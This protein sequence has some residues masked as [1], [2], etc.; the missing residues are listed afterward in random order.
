MKAIYEFSWDCGRQ[1]S[2]EGLF[3]EDKDKSNLLMI[4]GDD[5]EYC[6]RG[7]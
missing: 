6:S 7:W 1:G 4:I 3:V 2:V 5:Y